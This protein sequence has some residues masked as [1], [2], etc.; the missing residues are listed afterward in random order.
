MEVCQTTDIFVGR[1][2]GIERSN[3]SS[4]ECKSEE[5]NNDFQNV[6]DN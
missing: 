5:L 1:A 6:D 3:I 4:H 2:E